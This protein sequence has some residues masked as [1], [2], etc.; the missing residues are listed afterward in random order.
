MTG[1]SKRRGRPPIY[2]PAIVQRLLAERDRSGESYVELSLRSGIPAGTL[3]AGN[4]KRN[5]PA[6]PGPAFVELLSI[7]RD[8]TS[9]THSTGVT[10]EL[11]DCALSVHAPA[12][13]RVERLREIVLALRGV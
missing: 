3:A 1:P 13:T 7:P 11:D 8:P 2:D 10:V 12:D 6:Q 9:P 4:R 5:R